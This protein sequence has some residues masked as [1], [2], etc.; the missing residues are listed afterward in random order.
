MTIQEFYKK[1]KADPWKF[2]YREETLGHESR[3]YS[4][5][6]KALRNEAV[7]LGSK[8]EDLFLKFQQSRLDT[9][10]DPEMPE[11]RNNMTE[12]SNPTISGQLTLAKKLSMIA[13]DIGAVCPDGTN[14]QSHY[15]YISYE[16]INAI[17]RVK[18][19]EYGIAFVPSFDE[20]QEQIIPAGGKSFIRT[21][22]KGKMTILDADSNDK[23]EA[24]M[25]GA[26]N[27]YGGK[28]CGKAITECEKR[29][30]MKLFKI[31]T[32]DDVDPDGQTNPVPDNP[33]PQQG[34]TSR[35]QYGSGRTTP[36]NN[37]I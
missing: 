4:E 25:I 28:S 24:G 9:G 12:K 14:Q 2:I 17:I 22:V 13:K 20:I 18:C 19:A 7:A 31:S 27:D 16:K 21:T 1:L 32:K 33:H 23:I 6:L 26:D 10:I 11:E 5:S 35:R 8:F 34:Q 36:T 15:D 37:D 29:F 3:Y 30:L